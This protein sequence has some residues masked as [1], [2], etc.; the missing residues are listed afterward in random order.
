MIHS[1][2]NCS[3]GFQPPLWALLG[4]IIGGLITGLVNYSLQKS[5]F[6][7]NKEMFF[8]QNQGKEVVKELLEEW[9]NHKTFVGRTF[10]TLR[11]RI[12]GYT[13][14]ELRKILHELGAKKSTNKAGEEVWYLK[15][16][17]A[18]WI[19]KIKN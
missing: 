19:E 4:V 18:E 13:D 1:I 12:G 14:V 3:T 6:K 11:K 9:L 10:K 8:L 7:H 16:R 5:Q 15:V 2:I 17:E